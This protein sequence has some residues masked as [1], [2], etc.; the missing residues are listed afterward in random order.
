MRAPG[1]EWPDAVERPLL[2]LG[3]AAG[4]PGAVLFLGGALLLALA[5]HGRCSWGREDSTS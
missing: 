2:G 3:V 5:D 4:I 1:P